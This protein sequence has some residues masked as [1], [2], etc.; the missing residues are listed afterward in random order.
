LISISPLQAVMWTFR[1]S[2]RDV[3]NLYNSLSPVMQLATGGNMLNFGYWEGA[4]SP[5][6]AQRR[7]CAL[8]G[9]MAELASAKVLVDVGSGLGAPAMQWKEAHDVDVVSVNINQQQLFAARPD[10]RDGI[11]LVNATSTALPFSDRSADRIVALE[12]AQHF[13][14]LERFISESRRVLRD[15]GLLVMALPVMKQG[16]SHLKA[17]ARLGI[18]SLTW[19]SEHYGLEHVKSAIAGGGFTIGE[20]RHVGHQVYEP[21]TDYYTKNRQALRESILKE[22][23]PFIEGVLYKSLLKMKDASA[24]GVIDYVI[25]KAS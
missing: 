17:A 22:Y 14:P 11:T 12:S 4:Q 15:G 13:R 10:G 9:D 5:I 6:E 20:V 23:S 19:S 24:K 8:V 25:I 1:R 3:V 16:G 18:L 7:L 21:L 2:E